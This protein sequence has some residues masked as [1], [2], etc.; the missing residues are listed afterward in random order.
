MKKYVLPLALLA[1]LSASG[2]D[3]FV[4]NGLNPKPV[5]TATG[6]RSIAFSYDICKKLAKLDPQAHVAL[7]TGGTA[8]AKLKQDGIMGLDYE[9]NYYLEHPEWIDQ[10]HKLGMTVNVWTVN[11]EGAILK[12][13]NMGVD[14]ITTDIPV[15]AERIRHIYADQQGE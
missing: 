6:L 9:Q 13:N 4:Y 12:F 2:H 8:P 3:V 10:A 11:D 1:S 7:L 15:E 14:Y 5:Q